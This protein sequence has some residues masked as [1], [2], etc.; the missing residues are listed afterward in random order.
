MKGKRYVLLRGRE[1]ISHETKATLKKL[2]VL[3]RDRYI[4]CLFLKLCRVY[5]LRLQRKY[6]P[7]YSFYRQI[8][9]SP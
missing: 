9:Y 3:N 5:F 1:N 6:N 7:G 4:G 8:W 2:S